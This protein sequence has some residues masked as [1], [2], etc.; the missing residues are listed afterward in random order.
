[1]NKN[2]VNKITGEIDLIWKLHL[3]VRSH[4]PYVRKE[5]IGK[6]IIE[7]SAY[8]EM[9]GFSIKYNYNK[10]IEEKDVSYLNH[11]SNWINQNALIRLYALM[12]YC[13]FVSETISID[14]NID[15]WKELDLLRR[16]RNHFAHTDG[17]FNTCDDEQLYLVKEIVDYFNLNKST[18]DHIPINIDEVMEPIFDGCKRYLRKKLKQE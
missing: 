14:Q 11:L 18:Y 15:G 6:R 5:A 9:H 8:Y 12:N 2:D 1:M 3:N 10:P 13:G 17:R 7:S 16:L 4:F